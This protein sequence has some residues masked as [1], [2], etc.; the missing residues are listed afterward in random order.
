[1]T[2]GTSIFDY[3]DHDCSP[4]CAFGVDYAGQTGDVIA[5]AMSDDG[6]LSHR[7]GQ[8]GAWVVDAR[9]GG[10]CYECVYKHFGF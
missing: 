10:G 9:C 8:G 3:F 7:I 1:M 6:A 4:D 5:F 2:Q